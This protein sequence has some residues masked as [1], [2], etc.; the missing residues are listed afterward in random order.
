MY[1]LNFFLILSPPVLQQVQ[2]FQTVIFATEIIAG[3][4]IPNCPSVLLFHEWIAPT[5]LSSMENARRKGNGVIR[6]WGRSQNLQDKGKDGATV[7]RALKL[8]SNCTVV[9]HLVPK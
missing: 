1:N 4:G 9:S 2:Q 8:C 5:V 3:R 7:S 6:F